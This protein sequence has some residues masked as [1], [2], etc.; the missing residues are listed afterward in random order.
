MKIKNADKDDGAEFTC[1]VEG[2]KTSCKVNIEGQQRLNYIKYTSF[3]YRLNGR[4]IKNIREVQEYKAVEYVQSRIKFH[5]L[6]EQ[7][8]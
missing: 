2:D 5:I 3:I 8:T 6:S 4:Q 1:E 7:F